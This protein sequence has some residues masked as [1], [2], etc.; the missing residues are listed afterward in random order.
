MRNHESARG[1]LGAKTTPFRVGERAVR[2]LTADEV[3]AMVEHGVL[4]EDDR[5][6][7]LHGMLVRRGPKTPVHE[8]V[9]SQ[10][11]EWLVDATARTD[12]VARVASPLVVPDRTS[13]P[14]PDVM[15]APRP[16]R[17]FAFATTALLVVE[18]ADGT[19]R[20]DLEVK[21]PLYAAAG[22]PEV[23]VV[24][25]GRRRLHVLDEPVAG[26]GGYGRV[27]VIEDQ[28]EPLRPRHVDAPPITLG[29]LF[30]GLEPV[31]VRS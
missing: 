29:G 20:T 6:E 3:V 15:V 8:G 2:P 22:V 31:V 17:R 26:G 25:V 5:V 16:V 10:L 7:L 9:K 14:E 27:R 13:L 19:L 28:S 21:P 1:A 18:I 23:W 12:R 30:A 4:G 24:E 11:V